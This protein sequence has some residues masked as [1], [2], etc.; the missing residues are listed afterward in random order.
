V[1]L[2]ILSHLRANVVAYIALS[3][4]LSSTS[5]AAATKLLPANSVGTRQ[6]INH[7]LLGKDFKTGQL[8]KGA[9]GKTGPTG[10]AGP[11]G[12]TGARGT[13]GLQGL[14][15]QQGIQGERGVTGPSTGV[16][17]GDLTGN[18]PNPTIGDG[19][20]TPSKLNAFPSAGLK[21]AWRQYLPIGS[22]GCVA[23]YCGIPNATDQPLCWRDADFDTA[24]GAITADAC[25]FKA[26]IAGTYV[27][28][29]W[30][31]WDANATGERKIWLV[32]SPASGGSLTLASSEAPPVQESGKWTS[33]TVTTIVRLAANDSVAFH[34]YQ[35]SG[36]TLLLPESRMSMSW[37][38]P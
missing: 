4:V 30:A 6:V 31:S 10:S 35:D 29:L 18:Y 13:Q 20:V 5:Y 11:T 27:V 17:G 38:A 8:P 12:A 21:T 1:I 2:K 15:G 14:Q 3:I 23:Y 24:A 19:K 16:A 33:Q 28:S 37:I 36:G 7:S 34:A 26:P 25:N 32:E 22:G 9:K